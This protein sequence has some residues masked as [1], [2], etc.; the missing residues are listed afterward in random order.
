MFL[1]LFFFFASYVLG[2]AILE[3]TKIHLNSFLKLA[4]ATT[5]GLVVNVLFIFFAAYQFNLTSS[6]VL[7]VTAFTFIPSLFYLVV[8]TSLMPG[9]EISSLRANWKEI[10]LMALLMIV[11]INLFAKSIYL[12]NSS[13]IAGNRIV[14]T[15]WPIHFAFISSF[16]NGSNF[17]P[18]N[19]LYS[20]P[21]STYPFFA[22]F[23]SAILK[24]LGADYKIAFILPGIIMSLAAII[25]LYY[26]GHLITSSRKTTVIGILIG[27]FWGGLGFIYF[28]QDLVGSQNYLE[29][30]KYP[31]HEYTFYG[32]KNLW[33]FTFL[34]SEILPQRAFLFGLPMFLT[35]LLLLIRGI[36][37]KRKNMLL[38]SGYLVSIMPFFHMHSYLSFLIFDISFVFLYV[39][40]TVKT[41]GLSSAK[42]IFSKILIYHFMPIVGFGLI[43]LPFFRT[44]NTSQ[45]IGFNFG[46]MKGQENFFLFWFKNTGFFIPLLVAGV[47]ILRKNFLAL[48]IAISSSLLFILP[49][50]L[51]FAPW[52]YDNLKMFTYWYLMGAFVVSYLL[53]LLFKKNYV[54]KFAVIII[55][56]SLTAS[57]IVEIARL[58][59]T[60]KTK[61]TLWSKEDISIADTIIEKTEPDAK[62]LAAAV[63]DHPIADLAGRKMI[64]GFPG[65]AWSWGFSDWAQR[66][67][68]VRTMFH[69]DPTIAPVLIK[70]YGID[71]VFISPRERHFEPKLNED[72]FAT[73]YSLIAAGQNYKLYKVQ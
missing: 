45:T 19:P 8:K 48:N 7:I 31:P 44:L 24:V 69:A 66:E 2:A 51:R 22:D 28:L 25:L 60:E 34:Y 61:L 53:V 52:P 26:L 11:V 10:S 41:E 68:D 67:N 20:G 32:E 70:K 9:F 1:S 56:L 39:L 46:W 35:G 12:E 33:F 3:I 37:H 63:H 21:M 42:R 65:N 49:N 23:L 6:V 4:T 5:V 13:I 29:F 43:Q 14:W 50:I 57:G 17:P 73:N 71:Y 27:L 54:L 55:F 40:K 58:N 36:Y 15:D 62:I 30:L 16:A 64:I 18:Q 72:Y 59:N 38:F 47:I